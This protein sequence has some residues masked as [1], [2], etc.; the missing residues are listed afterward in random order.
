MGTE[1][2]ATEIRRKKC[3]SKGDAVFSGVDI[4]AIYCW[5]FVDNI[6]HGV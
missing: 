5:E 6:G 4:G 1:I 2:G 3:P